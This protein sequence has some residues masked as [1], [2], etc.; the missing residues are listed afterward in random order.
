VR[1]DRA[2]VSV[3]AKGVG[4][5]GTVILSKKAGVAQHTCKKEKKIIR[6]SECDDIKFK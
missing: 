6:V 1:F 5:G 2:R 4:S 3:V